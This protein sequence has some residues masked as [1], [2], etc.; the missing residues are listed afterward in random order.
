MN[1]MTKNGRKCNFKFAYAEEITIAGNDFVEVNFV[2]TKCGNHRVK[3]ISSLY[4]IRCERFS[5]LYGDAQ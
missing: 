3:R 5:H 1:E 4:N 2:C